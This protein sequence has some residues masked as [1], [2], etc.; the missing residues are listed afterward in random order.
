MS[1]IG[2]QTVTACMTCGGVARSSAGHTPRECI[3]E[4]KQAIQTIRMLSQ[5]K[6]GDRA[7]LQVRMEGINQEACRALGLDPD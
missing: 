6:P 1:M 5:K 4:L 7:L 3:T 2:G